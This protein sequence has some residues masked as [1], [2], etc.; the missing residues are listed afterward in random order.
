MENLRQMLQAMKSC[1]NFMFKIHLKAAERQ[2]LNF[3]FTLQTNM[4]KFSY[5]LSRVLPIL[6]FVTSDDVSSTISLILNNC[7]DELKRGGDLH[8][9]QVVIKNQDEQPTP[10]Y[11][12]WFWTTKCDIGEVFTGFRG[13]RGRCNSELLRC[14]IESRGRELESSRLNLLKGLVDEKIINCQRLRGVDRELIMA[15]VEKHAAGLY[16]FCAHLHQYKGMP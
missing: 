13:D 1:V 6:V 5:H 9:P 12:F 4:E 7:L 3:H 2:N 10:L 14:K 15:A 16:I 11:D 8:P